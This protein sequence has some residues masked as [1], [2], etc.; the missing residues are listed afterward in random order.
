MIRFTHVAIAV[1]FVATGWRELACAHGPQIQVTA[2]AGK[3]V[4][5][6]LVNDGPYSATL[7]PPTSVYVMPVAQYQG[8][9][10]SHPNAEIDPILHIPAFPSGPGLAYGYGYDAANP[11]PFPLGSQFNLAFTVGL[12]AWNGSAFA[13]AGSAELEAFRGSG[14]NLVVAR[15]SD[16]GPPASIKFPSVISPS[17]GIS[18]A[19][20]GA[21]THT[22]VSFRFLG[23]GV[24]TNSTLPDGVY[25]AGL[26][27]GS[28]SASLQASDPFY[29]VLTKNA[30]GSNVAAAVATLGI[31]SS[32]V[33]FAPEP[34]TLVSASP[35]VVIALAVA[36]RRRPT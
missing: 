11:A 8:V 6:R 22:S 31:N 25:L 24:S 7:T 30:G 1:S 35:V 28:T 15:T 29:F 34:N 13:D 3:I 2:D 19:A 10:Y 33:Q 26:Q 32:A 20:D 27:L 16:S 23:D 9:W 17:M 14:V 4:T 18:F 12:K 36:R 21:E 5:R